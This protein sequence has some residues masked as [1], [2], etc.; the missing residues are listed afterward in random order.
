MRKL[1]VGLNQLS[2]IMLAGLALAACTTSISNPATAVIPTALPTLTAA[3]SEPAIPAS[4]EASAS[5]VAES[6][7]ASLPAQTAPATVTSLPDPSGFDWVEVASGLRRPTAMADPHDGS[8]R[9]LVLEQIGIIRFLENGQVLSDPFLDI[10]AKIT[11]VGSEQGLLGIALD[12]EY[13]A[14]GLF[15]LDYTDTSGN[16]VIARYQRA[17]GGQAADPTSEQILMHIQQPFANHNGGQLAFGPDGFL[18]IGMGDGGSEGDPNN[19]AQNPQQTLGKILRIDVRNQTKY[20]IPADNPYAKSG[21]AAEVW[22]LGLR[23]P[24]RF[25]FDSLA[26]DLYIADVGQN[27]YEEIDFVPAGSPSGLNFGW[28]YYEGNHDYRGTAPLDRSAYAWPAFEYGHDQGC[29]VTGGYVY[30]GSDL[31]EFSGVYL[32]GDYC[33]GIVWGMIKDANG[34]TQAERLFQINGNISS[35]G[36]D[37]Q[38]E[39]YILDHQGNRVLKLVRK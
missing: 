29:S 24:W 28:N 32:F 17:S 10:S 22:A 14:N 7:A 9:L 31:P 21:G 25:S 2:I 13:A 3:A 18:Y 4:P 12:P 1:P 19:N 16:T 23:N 20:A 33:S 8:G 30:R 6:T 35:F 26:G 15:Y 37:S 36:Q 27:K 39:V 11:I 34:N 5:L 38:G